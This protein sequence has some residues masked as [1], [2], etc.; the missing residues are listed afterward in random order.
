[1]NAHRIT[2]VCVVLALVTACGGGGGSS[3]RPAPVINSTTETPSIVDTFGYI[4]TG[5]YADVLRNCTY[6]GDDT[7]T[8]SLE[9][10]PFLGQDAS[11]PTIDD[12][13]DRVLVSHTWMGDNM[14]TFLQQLPPDMLLM[15]RSVTAIVIAS[16]IRPAFY[17]PGRG[18]IYLDTDFLWLTDSQRSVVTQEEDF[19][20]NFG[21]ALQFSMPWRYVRNN[22]RLTSF[23]NTDGSRDV[24]SLLPILGFLLYHELAHAVDFMPQS[25]MVGL[26]PTL[27]ASDAI[28]SGSFLSSQ[29]RIENELT[30]QE[31]IDLALV[32][33]R[34]DDPTDA[35]ADLTPNDLVPEFSND[36]A[37]QYYSYSNQFEDFA[38]MFET[39]MMHYHFGYEKDTGITTTA[40]FSNDGIVAWGQRGR[41]SDQL[42]YSRA[43]AAVQSMY[44]GDLVALETFLASLPAPIAMT[45][46]VSWGENLD[47]SGLGSQSNA[48]GTQLDKNLVDDI[49]ERRMIR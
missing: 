44:P 9:T 13:M 22:E 38:T 7:Q 18:A 26:S 48:S 36:G 46:G 10:L 37:I 31:L 27:T 2:T 33:F 45:E 15:L 35:Q 28:N 39:V 30:S 19:R 21:N 3:S 5:P 29:W 24:D 6:A 41:I 11:N 1:M 12:V 14:R 8:C 42:A 4:S 23:I 34:G 49:L 16:D 17:D 43:L 20:A 25:K 47:L 40:E 32:S